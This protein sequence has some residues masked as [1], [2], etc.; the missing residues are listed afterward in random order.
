MADVVAAADPQFRAPAGRDRGTVQLP[1]AAGADPLSRTTESI[2]FASS[3]REEAADRFGMWIF[4]GSEA[5]LFGGLMLAYALSRRHFPEGFAGGSRETSFVLGTLNTAVLLTSSLFI[6]LA[7]LR[8]D[9]RLSGARMLLLATAV[10]GLVFLGIK[11]TEYADD[12]EHGLAP[13]FG[14]PFRYDG[15]DPAGARIFFRF[16]F[17]LTALHATH[18]IAGLGLVGWTA[19]RWARINE[20]TRR[21]RMT[22]VTLYWHFIDVVWVFLY[23]L[24]YLVSR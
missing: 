10:L 22:A 11:F 7:E 14:W 17:A 3:A 13:L 6:A 18:L 8:S 12:I 16:Y 15:P 21:R 19:L 2:A 1:H 5:L 20:A 4:L 9:K 24:L 23:P